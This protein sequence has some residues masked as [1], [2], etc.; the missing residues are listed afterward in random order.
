M[1]VRSY[2]QCRSARRMDA[3]TS[4]AGNKFIIVL[5]R[6]FINPRVIAVEINRY[7]VSTGGNRVLKPLLDSTRLSLESGDGWTPAAL[8]ALYYV[9]PGRGVDIELP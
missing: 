9:C 8:L 2:L 7:K 3:H 1:I 5:V 6:F 4:P